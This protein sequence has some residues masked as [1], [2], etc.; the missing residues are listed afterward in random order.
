VITAQG[1]AG[2]T[3]AGWRA[4]W[5]D[6]AL[7]LP[8]HHARAELG[9]MASFD[10]VLAALEEPE[11]DALARLGDD[12]ARA[13]A[14]D[15]LMVEAF[16]RRHGARVAPST[17]ARAAGAARAVAAR[18]GLQPIISYPLYI[19]HNPMAPGET[20]LFTPHPAEERFVRMHRFIEDRFDELIAA[21]EAVL[22]A[23]D[24][25]AAYRSI[26]PAVGATFARVNRVMA[27]FRDPER[28]PRDVFTHGFR[29][30]YQSV[31]DP[32]TG[33]VVL[34]GPSG[35]QSPTFRVV[36]MLAGYRDETLDAWTE[37]IGRYH[38]PDTRR[39]LAN[40]RVARDAGHALGAA[41][42]LAL[43]GADALPH[44]HPDY[45]RHQADLTTIA[46]RGGWLTEAAFRVLA[47]HGLDARQWPGDGGATALSLPPAGPPVSNAATVSALAPLAEL[48][49]MLFGFHAEHVAVAAVQIG[50][51]RGTGG[52]SG[53]EF[54]LTALFRRAFP[55]LW[56]RGIGARV[57]TG[58]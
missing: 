28:M 58:A 14:L 26:H 46:L 39:W 55:A 50:A 11:A 35:L 32:D 36:A 37:R 48:E 1:G 41:A 16:A 15:V 30:Y 27:A 43:G 8:G 20:R 2:E 17:M 52:T 22:D 7:A 57:A 33:E 56:E 51:V 6:A 4:A 21:L 19:R 25:L 42:R 45:A 49:A 9:D 29:P 5:R 24:V 34:D 44:L 40:A 47:E 53:V 23:P 31:L 10:A 13:V 54:L 12:E 18:T 38:T 3:T